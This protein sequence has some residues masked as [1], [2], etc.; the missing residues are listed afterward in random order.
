MLSDTERAQLGGLDIWQYQKVSGGFRRTVVFLRHGGARISREILIETAR[1]LEF[2][3]DD[4]FTV[5][6]RG[7]ASADD[8][9]LLTEARQIFDEVFGGRVRVRVALGREA[10]GLVPCVPDC[11]RCVDFADS[12]PPDDLPRGEGS[13]EAVLRITPANMDEVPGWIAP[14][15]QTGYNP[16]AAEVD[17]TRTWSDADLA[18]LETTLIRLEGVASYFRDAGLCLWDRE[19]ICR[20]TR[21][22]HC[23]V[24]SETVAIS[25]DGL[26][27]ACARFVGYDRT[28]AIGHVLDS[29]WIPMWKR[30]GG[31][32]P[33]QNRECGGYPVEHKCLGGCALLNVKENGDLFSGV[34]SQCRERRL[35]M[36]LQECF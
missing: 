8:L 13:C 29:L 24:G 12:A 14:L 18:Q 25:P 19:W 9:G 5:E 21:G 31:Y 36:E 11:Q 35:Q 2:D 23:G 16:I 26:Q 4:E 34:A 22:P 17:H 3:A 1:G 27:Y 33:L 28:Q 32:H 20:G 15:F 6:F 7:I 10:V 30:Y